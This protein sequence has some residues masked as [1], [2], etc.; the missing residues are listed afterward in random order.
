MRRSVTSAFSEPDD[1]ETA[2]HA[3]GCVSFVTTAS[4]QFR[5]RVT[6]VAL[7]GMR[8]LDVHESVARIAFIKV[9]DDVILVALSR[10]R[11]PDWFW[12]G[13]EVHGGELATLGPGGTA[14]VR[15][16][17]TIHWSAVWL[18]SDEF[19]RLSRA[20]IGSPV[21]L[22][23]QICR[24]RPPAAAIRQLGSLHQAVIKA[25]HLRPDRLG[26]VEAA[27][28][29]E[30]QLVQAVTEC[31]AAAPKCKPISSGCVAQE[32]MP[33]LE[34][35]LGAQSVEIMDVTALGG[36]LGVSDRELRQCCAIRLGMSPSHYLRLRRMHAARLAL[37]R[38][39]SGSVKVAEVAARFG[40]H[41]A[42]RFARLYND[43]FGEQPSQTMRH[44][45]PLIRKQR[46]TSIIQH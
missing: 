42:G 24:W 19:D 9:P 31:F 23:H 32:L 14:H 40:F 16:G 26:A 33:R 36:A 7:N 46:A 38:A 44:G 17:G 12:N 27:H 37:R 21:D 34:V 25:A 41:N 5:A 2:M 13:Q 15:T 39:P 30:Q 6:Q 8:L 35:L 45:P 11:W 18:K 22:P 1:F 43:F 29:L 20:L 28:G 3:E 4:G 10:S